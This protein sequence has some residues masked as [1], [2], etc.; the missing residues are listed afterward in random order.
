MVSGNDFLK[1]FNNDVLGLIFLSLEDNI[2]SSRGITK[3]SLV[4]HLNTHLQTEITPIP[5]F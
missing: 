2:N 4:L 1:W 5:A 3:T